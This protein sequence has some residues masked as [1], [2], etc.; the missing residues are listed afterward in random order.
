[1]SYCFPPLS[2]I[3]HTLYYQMHFVLCNTKFCTASC[4]LALTLQQ[5]YKWETI[6]KFEAPWR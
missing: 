1:M 6:M 3:K 5:V 4:K 2:I